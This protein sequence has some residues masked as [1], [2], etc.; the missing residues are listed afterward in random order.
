MYRLLCRTWMIL[1]VALAVLAPRVARAETVVQKVTINVE[2]VTIMLQNA[3]AG[4][5]IVRRGN[6]HRILGTLKKSGDVASLDYSTGL[7]EFKRDSNPVKGYEFDLVFQ[8]EKGP[9]Y[10]LHVASNVTSSAGLNA[11][12]GWADP[13]DAKATLIPGNKFKLDPYK[14]SG[15]TFLTLRFPGQD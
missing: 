1:G 13:P 5:V 8:P 7:L 12:G 2:P 6:D 15:K 4:S 11:F 10:I 3:T 14:S 9:A